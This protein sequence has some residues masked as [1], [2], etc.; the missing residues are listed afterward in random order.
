M[1]D[2]IRVLVKSNGSGRNLAMYYVDPVSG[3]RVVKTTRTTDQRE[4]ERVAGEWEKELQRGGGHSPSKITWQEF[5]KRYETEKL[6]TLSAGTQ[7]SAKYSLNHLERL[8]APDRLCKLTTDVMSKFQAKLR[9]AGMIDTTA[10]KTLRHCKAALRWAWRMGMMREAPRVEIPKRI[11]GQTMAKARA[12]TGEEFDRMLA[13]VPKKRPEDSASWIHYLN[14]LW[15]SGLR[16]TESLILSWDTN[17]TFAIDLL[18]KRPV[19]VI[20]AEAQKSGKDEV[21][22]MTPDFAQFL[23]ATSEAQRIGRVFVLLSRNTGKPMIPREVGRTISEIGE[24][25]GVV[26]NREAKKFASAHD[27]RRSFCSRWA[28]RV[29]PAVL[30]KLARHSEINTTLKYYTTID[31]ADIADELWANFGPQSGNDLGNG[32]TYGNTGQKSDENQSGQYR[33]KSLSNKQ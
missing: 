20:R 11:K 16:L 9:E 12:V 28:P 10:A 33:R 3:K 22:P 29:K 1:S 30:Q 17:D 5:R 26:V 13:A 25:A 31:A 15:L 24:W 14:G 18:G 7:E 19:F 8:L 4:A 32:N 2:E 6:P 27:L 21:L 23:L